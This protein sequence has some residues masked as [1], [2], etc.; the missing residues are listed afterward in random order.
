MAS[1]CNGEILRYLRTLFDVGTVAGLTDGQLLERFT[2]G[3]G[4]SAELAFAALVERH[5]PMV[6]RVC[7]RVLRDPH[8]AE[9]AFQATFLVLVRRARA[10]RL[11]DS[12]GSW[13]HG[14]ALRVA[15]CARSAALRRRSHEQRKGA[16]TIAI[17][18]DEE[19]ESELGQVVHEELARLPGRFREVALLCLLEGS[20]HEEASLRLGCPVG[21]VKSRLATA[22]ARLRRRLERRGLAPGA[23]LFLAILLE[24]AKADLGPPRMLV[25]MTA[26]AAMRVV[27]GQTA[28]AGA[29]SAPVAALTEG[30]LKAMLM[31][32][33]KAAVMAAVTLGTLGVGVAMAQ[34]AGPGFGGGGA[35]PDRLR[36][37]E[38]KLDRLLEA[39]EHSGLPTAHAAH[40][41]NV[42]APADAAKD[43]SDTAPPTHAFAKVAPATGASAGA[44]TAIAGAADRL[45]RLEQ[46]LHELEVRIAHIEARLIDLDR[47]SRVHGDE[48][49]P[50]K[51]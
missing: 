14:V 38:R 1:S 40:G 23:G 34:V 2:A 32:K 25:E 47:T 15:T 41:F 21:T 17:A 51:R 29:I 30:V 31:S 22:R 9:D 46:R 28:A 37:V 27:A 18:E 43:K 7:R 26:A 4:E 45:D 50:A 42:H 8:D 39:V 11:H 49:A 35:E 13:L 20:T 33:I 10:I 16:V 44:A 19:G 24:E 3:R 36:E 6:L 48:P 5:G 12:V